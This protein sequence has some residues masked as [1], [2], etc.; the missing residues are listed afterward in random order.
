MNLRTHFQQS[1]SSLGPDNVAVI[2]ERY[3]KIVAERG[4]D[5][6]IDEIHDA[7]CRL[8]KANLAT[9]SVNYAPMLSQTGNS[10]REQL[11]IANKT[12]VETNSLQ[13]LKHLISRL[14][15]NYDACAVTIGGVDYSAKQLAEGRPQLPNFLREEKFVATAKC[16]DGK[17]RSLSFEVRY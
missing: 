14:Q 17:T 15:K 2:M 4:E 9:A 3:D 13:R 6:A 7:F 8:K 12:K 5:G 11:E 10:I 16:A 1:I